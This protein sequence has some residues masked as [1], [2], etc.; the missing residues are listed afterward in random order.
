MYPYFDI[1]GI[2]AEG[3]L[4]EWKWLVKGSFSLLAVNAFG[5]LFLLSAEGMIYR[6][7][8]TG[9]EIS[10]I[11]DSEGDFRK[12][13]AE[14]AKQKEWFLVDAENKAAQRG[15]IPKK[16]ECVGSKIP[17]VFKESASMPDNLCVIALSQ[18]VSFIGD[19]LVQMQDVPNGGKVRLRIEP[20]PNNVDLNG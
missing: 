2:S 16:G 5:D 8:I 19:V 12:H 1:D 3:L 14:P 13:A 4:A 11:A 20:G 9:G 7:D 18:Y 17:W 15:Y 6:L 10:K